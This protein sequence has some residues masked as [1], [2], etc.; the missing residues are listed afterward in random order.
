MLAH[1]DGMLAR[2][3]A[4]VGPYW[5]YVEPEWNTDDFG[6]LE[7]YIYSVFFASGSKNHGIY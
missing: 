4:H 2:L 3:E 1:L 6:A 7:A 5:E